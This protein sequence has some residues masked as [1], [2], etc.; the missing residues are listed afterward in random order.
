[1]L[2]ILQ[3][4][5]ILGKGR[6]NCHFLTGMR[7]QH[8]AYCCLHHHDVIETQG[9]FCEMGVQEKKLIPL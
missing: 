6:M 9:S 5:L 2:K 8:V 7:E 1:M 3:S 4:T